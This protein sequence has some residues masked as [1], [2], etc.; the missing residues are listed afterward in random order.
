MRAYMAEAHAQDDR[1]VIE[2]FKDLAL[3]R[4]AELHGCRRAERQTR[5]QRTQSYFTVAMVLDQI[6]QVICAP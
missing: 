2:P 1:S 3:G 5:Y 4:Q 6:P